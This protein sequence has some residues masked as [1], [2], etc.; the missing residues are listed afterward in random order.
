[1]GSRCGALRQGIEDAMWIPPVDLE[2]MDRVLFA[3]LP[4][5]ASLRER[6]ALAATIVNLYRGGLRT[7][8]ELRR[9]LLHGSAEFTPGVPR[10]VGDAG[11][12]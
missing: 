1:M 11:G 10:T 12:D 4:E 5:G 7:E 3:M 8:A 6:E 2:I 9:E